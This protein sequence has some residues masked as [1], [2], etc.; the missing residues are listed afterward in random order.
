MS[1][2]PGTHA[3]AQGQGSSLAAAALL[4]ACQRRRAAQA[5]L[6]QLFDAAQCMVA[7][8]L[9]QMWQCKQVAQLLLRRFNTR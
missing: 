8:T 7:A 3:L 5:L 9:L 6:W 2:L 4:Q 1:Q